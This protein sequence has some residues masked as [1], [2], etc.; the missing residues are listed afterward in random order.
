MHSSQEAG[1]GCRPGTWF[2]QPDVRRP[3][4]NRGFRFGSRWFPLVPVGSRWFPLVPVGSLV[5]FRSLY[6]LLVSFGFYWF[7]LV[8][9]VFLLVPLMLILESR[10]KVVDVLS[11]RWRKE[12]GMWLVRLNTNKHVQYRGCEFPHV[13]QPVT[14][15]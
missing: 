14:K 2:A 8:P 1:R 7:L 6:F 13:F 5:P 12:A 3:F 4:Q 9:F 11:G 15:H 10:R